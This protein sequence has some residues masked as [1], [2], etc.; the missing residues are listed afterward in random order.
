MGKLILKIAVMMFI[1]LGISNYMMYLTTGKSPFSFSGKAALPELGSSKNLLPAR[2][3]TAYRWRD[4]NGV[5]HYSSEPPP[6]AEAEKLE[7]DPSTNLIQGLELKEKQ[8]SEDKEKP[9]EPEMPKANPYNPE[10][11]KKLFDDAKKVQETLDQRYK[12]IDKVN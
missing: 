4:E 10:T 11:I 12:D 9:A 6:N 3:E 8:A 5:I 2:K 1:V 7:V